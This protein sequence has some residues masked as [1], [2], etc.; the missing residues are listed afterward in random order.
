MFPSRSAY[1]LFTEIWESPSSGVRWLN[2]MFCDRLSVVESIN[3][4]REKR[5]LINISVGQKEVRINYVSY[6]IFGK[7]NEIC[8][9][10]NSE[11]SHELRLMMIPIVCVK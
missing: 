1:R 7:K 2:A 9:K 4:R 5:N 10:K 8:K 11:L 6:A 3:K